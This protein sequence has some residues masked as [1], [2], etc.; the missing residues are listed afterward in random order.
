MWAIVYNI[1]AIPFAA[2]VWFPWTHMLVP[3]QFAGLAM[4]FSS[5]SVVASSMSLRLYKRP[6]M[7]DFDARSINLKFKNRNQVQGIAKVLIE[8]TR[9]RFDKIKTKFNETFQKKSKLKYDKLPIRS[10]ISDDD[11]ELGGL[12][13]FKPV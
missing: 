12:M 3:P 5:I 1:L 11:V 4:A 8:K 7:L 2:G 10:S 6:K 13:R 9:R